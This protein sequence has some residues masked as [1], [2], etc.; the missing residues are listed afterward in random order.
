MKNALQGAQML[1]VAFG[2]LV[3]VPLLTGLDPKRCTL[4]RRYRYPFIP[5]Y[6]TPF[7]ANL[8]SV[9]F[10]IHR[11]YHVWYSNLGCRCN[12]GRPYGGGCCVCTNGRVN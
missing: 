1:F 12:H 8:L 4:W 3:L 7:S 6:Y 10:R 2:A 11:A 9:F 5:T